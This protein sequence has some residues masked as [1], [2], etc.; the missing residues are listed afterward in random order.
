ME[1]NFANH[2]Q[3][4]WTETQ[5]NKWTEIELH[6]IYYTKD[7]KNGEQSRV[8]KATREK[9]SVTYKGSPRRTVSF[10]TEALKTRRAWSNVL[11]VMKSTDVNPEDSTQ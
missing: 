7:N 11:Q 2:L 10:L 4:C 1:T 6:I 3:I 9:A 5:S 8:L